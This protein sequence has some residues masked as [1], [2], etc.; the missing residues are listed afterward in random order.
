MTT[1]PRGDFYVDGVFD[2]WNPPQ[3]KRVTVP[4]TIVDRV[5]RYA[6]RSK[7]HLLRHLVPATL[8][9]PEMVFRGL[10]RDLEGGPCYVARPERTFDN[11]GLARSM[12]PGFVFAVYL[13]EDDKVYEWRLE[14]ADDFASWEERFE[15]RTWPRT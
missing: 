15:E 1:V 7:F 4:A 14:P 5:L 12:P 9:R 2:P 8:E 13:D 6:P 3:P 10:R 11:D